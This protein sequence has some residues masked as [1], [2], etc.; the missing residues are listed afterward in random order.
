MINYLKSRQNYDRLF[1]TQYRH[2]DMSEVNQQTRGA[3]GQIA[4]PGRVETE[5]E[6]HASSGA[7]GLLSPP[8]DSNSDVQFNKRVWSK[9][10]KAISERVNYQNQVS[11][12]RTSLPRTPPP[13]DPVQALNTQ[14]L[15]ALL[16][17]VQQL[18]D[19]NTEVAGKATS[20]KKKRDPEAS[21]ESDSDSDPFM[22]K[23]EPG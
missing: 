2:S 16:D 1:G 12:T 6:L 8:S 22:N 13:V 15:Q 19:G 11:T 9:V 3:F 21:S 17:L 4:A 5:L 10:C 7:Q 20:R 23:K 14:N 18:H